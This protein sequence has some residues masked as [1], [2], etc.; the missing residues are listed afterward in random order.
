MMTEVHQAESSSTRR[1]RSR[2]RRY[3]PTKMPPEEHYVWRL[4]HQL[5]QV[6]TNRRNP[7]WR[8]Y[9]R[10]GLGL[11]HGWMYD[12]DSFLDHVGLP[13]GEWLVRL[14]K[15][16]GWVPNN[17]AWSDTRPIRRKARYCSDHC[18]RH[19]GREPRQATPRIGKCCIC[20]KP[21]PNALCDAK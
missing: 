4:W 8:N 5:R 12:F 2:R 21:I 6:T 19:R 7:S 9:G 15:G 10:K 3:S 16:I 20:G 13:T 14:D 17:I 18:S 11:W 1:N